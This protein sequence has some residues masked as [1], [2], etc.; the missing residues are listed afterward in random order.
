MSTPRIVE[1]T[2][3][4]QRPDKQKDTLAP[5]SER[6]RAR[7]KPLESGRLPRIAR[8]MALA[9]R[10]EQLLRTGSSMTAESRQSGTK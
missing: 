8:L 3:P 1:C 4:P 7:P 6:A 9:L 2:L 10:F 5:V